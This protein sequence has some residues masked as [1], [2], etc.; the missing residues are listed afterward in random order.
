M[1][2]K[3]SKWTYS[4]GERPDTVNALEKEP[5]GP[6]YLRWHRTEWE[7][8]GFRVRVN[9]KLAADAVQEAK[10]AAERKNLELRLARLRGKVEPQKL[11]VGRAWDLFL[12]EAEGALPS[13]ST[14]RRMYRRISARWRAR[15]G[16]E[17]PWQQVTRNRVEAVLRDLADTPTEAWHTGRLLRRLWKWLDESAG[18]EGINNPT[19]GIQ[20]GKLLS[21][22]RPH[23]PRYTAAEVA[24]LIETR[25]DPRNDPRWA[26]FLALMDDSGR[27]GVELRS[28]RRSDLD[29]PL[30]S[31]LP[32]EQAP[33]GWLWFA[34]VKGQQGQPHPLTSFERRE[35]D[36]AL[37]TWAR[38]LEDE[39]LRNPDF[40]WL[41]IPGGVFPQA[42]V[43]RTT[44]WG[45]SHPISYTTTRQDWLLQAETVAGIQHVQGR[46]LHG[47][48]RAWADYT[49]NA[50]GLDA[51]TTAG[52]WSTRQTLEGTYLEDEKYGDLSAAREAHERKRRGPNV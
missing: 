6:V 28:V 9:G 32:V 26:L 35:I 49:R 22:R 39:R 16:A 10:D 46:A 38:E 8:L 43:Y 11:T 37:A 19:K 52:G 48:R 30:N 5:G 20:F 23:R 13:S 7:P 42:G 14:A 17:T 33:Y 2:R 36:L 3:A 45:L 18:Y 44:A 29:R 4:Y 12:D 25:H 51:A 47:V 15:L 40:D 24:K 27:R 31:Q 34:G 41:L 50:I 21:G 1:P